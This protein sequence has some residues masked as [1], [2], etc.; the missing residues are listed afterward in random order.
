MYRR[1]PWI[2]FCND[3]VD[4]P[5]DKKSTICECGELVNLKNSSIYIDEKKENP[6]ITILSEARSDYNV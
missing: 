2:H 3:R 5:Y 1:C 4:I 6:I